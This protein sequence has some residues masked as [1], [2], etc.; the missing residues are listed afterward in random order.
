MPANVAIVLLFVLGL[1]LV[2]LALSGYGSADRT[3]EKHPRLPGHDTQEQL[4][5]WKR[6]HGES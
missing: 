3:H 5:R 2:G 4:E 1:A 6:E